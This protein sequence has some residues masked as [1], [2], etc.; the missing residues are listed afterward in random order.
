M[1]PICEI[2]T[3]VYSI[4][5]NFPQS[6]EIAGLYMLLDLEGQLR[7]ALALSPQQFGRSKSLRQPSASS[8]AV[9]LN[10]AYS[11]TLAKC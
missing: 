3:L 4:T 10:M 1:G 9:H 8:F 7:G 5:L 2:T 11:F 6:G